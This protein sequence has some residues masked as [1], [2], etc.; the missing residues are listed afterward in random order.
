MLRLSFS[1]AGALNFGG[2]SN[3]QARGPAW[4]TGALHAAIAMLAGAGDPEILRVAMALRTWL[5]TES[6]S[7]ES[8]LGIPA[9]WRASRVRMRRDRLYAAL[10]RHFPGLEGRPLARAITTA[11]SQ[12]EF[13][14]WQSDRRAGRR[15]DGA[16]GLIF[17]LLA[18]PGR[19]LDEEALRKVVGKNSASEYPATAR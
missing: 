8:A 9:T 17:E 16:R 2:K 5:D 13:G 12:Y 11:I 7:L 6:T 14:S 15:P 18:L 10:A 3:D 19:R 1:K 4:P